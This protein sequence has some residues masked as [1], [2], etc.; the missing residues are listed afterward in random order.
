MQLPS[1]NRNYDHGA[2]L[3]FLTLITG[4]GWIQ[5]AVGNS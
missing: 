1:S 3:V 2:K 5:N 4:N